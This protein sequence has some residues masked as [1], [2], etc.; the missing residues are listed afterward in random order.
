MAGMEVTGTEGL[1]RP[2]RQNSQAG[3]AVYHLWLLS[4][5]SQATVSCLSSSVFLERKLQLLRE[6]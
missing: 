1:V 6:A 4:T 2:G 5:T 3:T